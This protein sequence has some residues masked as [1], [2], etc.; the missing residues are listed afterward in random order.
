MK[1]INLGRRHG[2]F[3]SLKYAGSLALLAL[4]PACQRAAQQAVVAQEPGSDTACVLDGMLLKDFP[5]PK[6]Q[7]HYAEGAPD[8][9]CDLNEL[10][11]ALLAPELSRIR[12]GRAVPFGTSCLV[13]A[14]KAPPAFA[15]APGRQRTADDSGAAER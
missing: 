2:L 3:T 7:I 8:F 14:V 6:G 1:T 15:G 5:G 4:L 9:F 12:A 10:F 13:V 11:N